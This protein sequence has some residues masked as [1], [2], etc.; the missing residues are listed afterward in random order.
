[1]EEVGTWDRRVED[2]D[3]DERN[4]HEWARSIEKLRRDRREDLKM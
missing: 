2:L 1:L 3:S 4:G